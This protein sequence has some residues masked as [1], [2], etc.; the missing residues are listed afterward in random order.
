[1]E[2]QIIDGRKLAENFNK[3]TQGKIEVLKKSYGIN[4]ALAVIIIGNNPASLIYVDN[5]VKKCN[6]LGIK[7]F[8][9]HLSEF[10]TQKE[11]EA[12]IKEINNNPAI[13]GLLIQLPLPSQINTQEI[14]NLINPLKDVDGFTKENTFALYN[15]T[16]NLIPCT[17]LGCIKLIQ[18][19]CHNLTGKKTVILG[20]SNI[21]GKPLS[22]LLLNHNASVTILHSK[23]ENIEKELKEA[24][25][26]ISAIGKPKFIKSE[27][28]NK[29]AIII[30]VGITRVNDKIVGDVDY[31]SAKRNVSYIT[32]VPGGVGPMTIAMLMQNTVL[33]TCK[34]NNID[35][36][37]L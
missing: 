20:R 27:W 1:M 7:S 23:S 22:L 30:D 33:A 17:P 25:I 36:D 5:K 26:I 32:P 11:V 4:P 24:D 15:N 13:N 29:K 2:A 37:K 9:Y 3:E 12:L 21:V 19:V 14:I 18:S 8:K 35:F 6:E 16:S 31:E 34:Q 10:T 28:L